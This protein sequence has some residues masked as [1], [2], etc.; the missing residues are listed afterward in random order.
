MGNT[1]VYRKQGERSVIH[2][3][4][5]QTETKEKGK[6]GAVSKALPLRVPPQSG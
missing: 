2:G 3:N 6:A 4:P 5:P 1:P